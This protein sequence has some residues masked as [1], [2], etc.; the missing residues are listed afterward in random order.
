MCFMKQIRL[1][2]LIR[3]IESLNICHA[4][5]KAE[6]FRVTS[7]VD[8]GMPRMLVKLLRIGEKEIIFITITS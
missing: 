6:Q 8:V 5:S 1:L 7:V 3:F 4:T 2:P